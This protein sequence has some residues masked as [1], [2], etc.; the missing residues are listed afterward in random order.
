MATGKPRCS[1]GAPHAGGN[2]GQLSAA[3]ELRSLQP[4]PKQQLGFLAFS[5]LCFNFGAVA[6]CLFAAYFCP[7]CNFWDDAR[8]SAK[9]RKKLEG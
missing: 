2:L 4:G 5:S 1:R 3:E 7:E 6:G 9:H 8:F